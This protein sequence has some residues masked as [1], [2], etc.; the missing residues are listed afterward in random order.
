MERA[1][2]ERDQLC[3]PHLLNL[4]LLSRLL[5]QLIQVQYQ[6]IADA[7]RWLELRPQHLLRAEDVEQ[8]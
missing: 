5:F 7:M 3:I 1:H 6:Q 4:T 8:P 2:P